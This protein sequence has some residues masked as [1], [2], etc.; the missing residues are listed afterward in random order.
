MNRYN[1]RIDGDVV[2]NPF[3][4]E[5]LLLNDILV[6][7]DIEV[8]QITKSNWTNI[9]SFYFPEE[10]NEAP[11]S[12]NNYSTGEDGQI[13]FKRKRLI[14]NQQEFTIDEFGQV[15][16]QNNI[17][18][19]S[20]STSNTHGTNSCTTSCMSSSSNSDDNTRWK[21]FFTIVAIIVFIAITCTTGWGALPVGVIGYFVLRAIWS[22]E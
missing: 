14:Q 2:A 1:I 3:T 12:E 11:V 16:S 17:G 6:F 18:G 22:G 5:E 13:S 15:V 20:N 21:I 4:Y 10:R 9:K 8:K 19:G 7:D